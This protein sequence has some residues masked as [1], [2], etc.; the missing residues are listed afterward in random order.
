[1]FSYYS[2]LD[3]KERPLAGEQ[4]PKYYRV[5]SRKNL[6]SFFIDFQF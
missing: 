2:G 1:M 4:V 6:E 3:E 5:N